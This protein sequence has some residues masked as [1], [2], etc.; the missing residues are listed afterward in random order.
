VS[1][2]APQAVKVFPGAHT[3]IADVK[4]NIRG[5]P[6]GVSRKHLPLI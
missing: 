2:S 1:G 6:R 3:L 4:G 5:V